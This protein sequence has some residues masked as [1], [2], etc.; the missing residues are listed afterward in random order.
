MNSSSCIYPELIALLRQH[1]NCVLATV[2]STQGST[3]Q[4]AGCSALIGSSGLLAG[5]VG[6]G[7][8]EL[9]VIQQSQLLLKTKQSALLSFE[10]YGEIIKGSESI[11]GG[12][13]TILLDASPELHLPVFN[14]LKGS[15]DRRQK[16]IL[17]TLTDASDSGDVKIE[18]HWVVDEDQNFDRRVKDIVTEMIYNAHTESIR[19]IYFDEKEV[20]TK[21]FALLESILPT[22]SLIIAGAGHIGQS[23]AT[24]GKFLGFAV[25]VWDDRTEY[26]DQTLIPDADVVLSGTFDKSLGQKPVQADSYLVIVTR[27]HKSDAEVLKKFI[28]SNAA[29][30][31]MIGSK[32]KVAQMKSSFLENGWANPEQWS[33]IHSP[34]GL[35]IGAQTVEEIAISIAAELVKVRS[36]KNKC[37]E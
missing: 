29:Y 19:T 28:G 35:N 3:P 31:G 7:I 13:M 16:G 20:F 5:T 15:L 9:K 10:L 18:R 12:N 25:T 34:V 8:T 4:K 26:A 1:I 27:G 22:P 37:D 36:E 33:R 32:A 6:G 11:C 2:V 23:L 21:G 24:L 14:Q 30:I 17:Q